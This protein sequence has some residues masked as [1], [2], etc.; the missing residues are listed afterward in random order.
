[1][2]L[3]ILV[4]SVSLYPRLPSASQKPINPVLTEQCSLPISSPVD[5]V[6]ARL[7][8]CPCLGLWFWALSL[9]TLLPSDVCWPCPTGL[10][11]L[12]FWPPNPGWYFCPL[13]LME[14][15]CPACSVTP[16]PCS[17]LQ[18]HPQNNML[19]IHWWQLSVAQITCNKHIKPQ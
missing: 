16:T 1:M 11:G 7:R 19:K 15:P 8:A 3:L 4:L 13:V 5:H 10:R 12:F 2:C 17:Y 9:T 6:Q 18:P 14:P